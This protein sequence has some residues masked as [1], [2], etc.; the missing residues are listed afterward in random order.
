L[1]GLLEQ[2]EWTLLLIFRPTDC[3]SCIR[4]GS[5]IPE[6]IQADQREQLRIA[7]LGVDT[8][9]EELRSFLS[10]SALPYPVYVAPPNEEAKEFYRSLGKIG[11]T[12]LLALTEGR[13]VRYATRLV[14]DKEI[15]DDRYASIL[16]YVSIQAK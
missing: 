8:N 3:Y 14:R 6:E 13:Q 15:R 5:D 11:N 4:Y 12:P 7:G 9:E 2:S 10:F 1:E 16:N